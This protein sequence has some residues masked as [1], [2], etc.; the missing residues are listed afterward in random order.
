MYAQIITM[1]GAYMAPSL[2]NDPVLYR[3]ALGWILGRLRSDSGISQ[4]AFGASLELT[5]AGYRK[6]EKGLTPNMDLYLKAFDLVGKDI[7]AVMGMARILV[8]AVEAEERS[9]GASLSPDE[10]DLVADDLYRAW[11]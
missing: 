3:W 7:V 10:R 8:R 2:Q 9:R 4:E 5:Q 11:N 1:P 6:I